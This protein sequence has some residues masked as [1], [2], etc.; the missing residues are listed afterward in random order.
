MFVTGKTYDCRLGCL[1]TKSNADMGLGAKRIPP[2]IPKEAD[3]YWV[4]LPACCETNDV[5]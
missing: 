3:V 2:P 5:M 1:Q 4:S